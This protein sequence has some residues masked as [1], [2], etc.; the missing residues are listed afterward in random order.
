MH[1]KE[2]WIGLHLPRRRAQEM[3]HRW[4][5]VSRACGQPPPAPGSYEPG[6]RG[7]FIRSS[8]S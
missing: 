4:R 8:R 6:Q 7:A 5:F 1:N 2:H 3:D